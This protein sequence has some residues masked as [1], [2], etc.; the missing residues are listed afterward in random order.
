MG[1]IMFT[2]VFSELITEFPKMDHYVRRTVL[3]I[4]YYNLRKTVFESVMSRCGILAS[5]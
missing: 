4:S 3:H 5:P 2:R 1:K